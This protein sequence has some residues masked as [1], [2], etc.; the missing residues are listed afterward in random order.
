MAFVNEVRQFNRFYTNVLG[1]IDQH[2]L[3]SPYSLEEVRVLYEIGHRENGNAKS[4]KQELRIDGGY[5]SRILKQFEKTGL[6]IRTQN[7][8]DGRVFALQLTQKG[9]TVLAELEQKSEAQ[10]AQLF[11]PLP[12]NQRQHV[13]DCMRA[14]KRSL[15]GEPA[16]PR[17]DI[18]V[19]TE[20]R[21]GDAGYLTYLQSKLYSEEH[22]Y[23]LAFEGYVCK[24]FYDCLMEYSPDK[25]RF[26][27]MEHAGTIIGGI[28]ILERP[29]N[30]AQLR[31]LVL[32]PDYRGLGLG[33][34]LVGRAMAYCRERGF[35]CVYLET[36]DCHQAAISL[37]L[38]AGFVK[39]AE[40]VSTAFGLELNEETYEVTL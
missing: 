24:T 35:N 19:R 28:A 9:Q 3:D 37:Y 30:R 5:L 17:D 20:L 11:S 29:E 27:I 40:H 18:T 36:T 25:D 13:V 38:K 4:L 31:W 21:A 15:S 2:L 12:E 34:E 39:T 1:L 7:A 22:G 10:I 33:K 32:H 8:S 16:V 14:I 26:W 6:I 23:G